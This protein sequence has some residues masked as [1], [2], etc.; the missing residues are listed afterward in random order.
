MFGE[1][2]DE[3]KA[4]EEAKAATEGLCKLTKEVLDKVDKVFVSSRVVDSPCVANRAGP[5]TWNVS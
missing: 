1:T 5:L 4:F 3:K 2:D